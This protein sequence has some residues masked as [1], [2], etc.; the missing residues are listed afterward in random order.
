MFPRQSSSVALLF[1]FGLFATSACSKTADRSEPAAEPV[2]QAPATKVATEE[3]GGTAPRARAVVITMSLKV[4]KPATT[5]ASL[6]TA[7]AE[8]DGYASEASAFV[9]DTSDSATFDVRVPI[10][11]LN[12][13]RDALAKLGEIV[14]EVERS[15]DVTEQQVDLGSRLASQ[16]TVEKRLLELLSTKAG[17]LADVI[18]VE[19][20]L[21][22]VRENI[23][24]ME[25]QAR[26]L[27]RRVTY[28]SVRI[29]VRG[30]DFA[31]AQTTSGKLRKAAFNGISVAQTI[32]V[33]TGVAALNVT[34]SLVMIGGLPMIAWFVLRRRK[35]AIAKAAA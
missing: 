30:R 27:D 8:V 21:G 19:K 12:V 20:E 10:A 3:H 24:R 26:I 4:D 9:T 28:A 11:K 7:L 6:R 29:D 31:S 17:T 25:A 5:M 1:S 32:A 15:E 13:F 22:T 33:D 2:P 18:A 34:P 23:E 14:N 35:H 16:R